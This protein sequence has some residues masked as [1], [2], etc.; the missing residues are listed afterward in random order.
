[1]RDK[2]VGPRGMIQ[3]VKLPSYSFGLVAIKKNSVDF[4]S[5][6][7]R[8]T[9]LKHTFYFLSDCA[10]A[11]PNIFIYRVLLEDTFYEYGF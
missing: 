11:L 6:Y 5:K 9:M 8:C 3:L 1:M 7:K 10:L 4:L 2:N